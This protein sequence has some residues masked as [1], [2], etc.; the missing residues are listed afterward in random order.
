MSTRRSLLPEPDTTRLGSLL[1]VVAVAAGGWLLTTATD[2][3]RPAA[4]AGVAGGLLGLTI[5]IRDTET[6]IGTAVATLLL[7]VP[8]LLGLVALG[9]PV[10]EI[11]P[12]A[13]EGEPFVRPLIGGLGVTIAV[14]VAAFGVVSTLDTGVGKGA[15]ATLWGTAVMASFGIGLAL[16]GLLV[17]QLEALT[18]VPIPGVDG[19]LVTEF[20]YRPSEPSVV[21]VTFWLLCFLLVGMLKL[22]VAV[23]PILELSSQTKQE[24]VRRGLSRTHSVL[25]LLFALLLLVTTMSAIVTM[26]ES[27]LGTFVGR[28]PAAFEL[29]AAPGLRRGLVAGIGLLTLGTLALGGLQFVTG[30]VTDTVG[31]LVPSA[32]AGGGAVAVAVVG[33]P[34][35]P[36]LLDRVPD[37]PAVPVDQVATAL[38]PPGVILTGLA[39]A[40]LLLTGV[41]SVIVTAGGF[42]YI[43][44]R[45]AGSAIASGSLGF[46]AI[47]VGVAGA[48]PL[49]VF[50]A[51][52]VS[53]LVWN[54]GE[55]SVTTRA[56]LGA[57]WPIQL[58]AIHT[59]SALGLAALG[60]GLAWGLYTNA[61]GRLAV[62][63]GTLVGV[64]A[65]T[66]GVLLLVVA[67]R[68]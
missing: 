14:G 49:V 10:R 7:P 33:S 23:A 45:T 41:L 9:L 8:S 34:V 21:L 36:G 3:T 19:S 25:N 61:L 60:V 28:F 46:G 52:A 20:V 40:M 53:I 54:I 22:L 56:E 62:S 2:T 16:A 48:E 66:V 58:E 63:G 15:V 18:A 37:T 26:G 17:V 64:L 4:V 47:A 59:F 55:R 31:S 13:M 39:I 42:K 67:L 35:V 12:L 6:P 65:S 38:T 51:V 11:V 32:L 50:A 29:F 57:L 27:D 30:R 43:P 24:A 44:R 68:G 1:L 5:L